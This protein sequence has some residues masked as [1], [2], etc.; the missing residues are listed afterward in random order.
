MLACNLKMAL[1]GEKTLVTH[2]DGGFVVLG[3][4]IR[5]KQGPRQFTSS[6]S[7]RPRSSWRWWRGRSSK[8]RGRALPLAELVGEMAKLNPVLRGCAV[9][10]RAA[11]P[12][13]RSLIF[14]YSAPWRML[15]WICHNH[16]PFTM[17]AAAPPLLRWRTA[18]ARTG[19]LS[20]TR[21]RCR[22]SAN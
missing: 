18:S 8:Q 1:S 10:F 14:G 3:F 16:P 21:R 2:A 7:S 13:R 9:Y 5:P 12:R 4:H 19:S 11:L 6:S 15:P 17:G 20:I 22:S